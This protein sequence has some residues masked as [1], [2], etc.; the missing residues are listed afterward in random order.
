MGITTLVLPM[1]FGALFTAQSP[2]AAPAP[3][4]AVGQSLIPV[5]VEAGR[6]LRL[7]L[8][9]RTTVNHVGQ[10]VS[11]TLLDPVY[12]HDR[13][14]LP[15]GTTAMGH[16]EILDSPSKA[17]RARAMLAGDFSGHRLVSVRF[18]TLV[19]EN[20][21]RLE[22]S[23]S[24]TQGVEHV[25]RKVAGERKRS[26]R[27]D[28]VKDM[29]IRA[30]PYHRQFLA[31]GTTY[32]ASL[33]AP[34]DLGTAE[35]VPHALPGTPPAPDSHLAA[36]L[37]TPVGSA[38]SPLGTPVE[39]VLTQPLFSS[40]GAVILPE[41]SKL[42]G[43]VTVS[44]PARR[45]RR[46]GQLR[47]LLTRVVDPDTPADGLRASLQGVE[48]SD[49]NRLS[50][51]EEGGVRTTSSPA[52]FA[53]PALAALAFAG[54]MHGRVDLDTDGMGP[55]TEYGGVVS[56]TT[57]GFIGMSVF[58]VAVNQLGR[59]VVIVTTSIGLARSLYAT[60]FARGAEVAFPVNTPLTLQLSPASFRSG[61][62]GNKR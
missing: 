19:L 41:G 58:G 18:D 29:A 22:I 1:I 46:T 52:R 53:A 51:D 40:A 13:I 16:I 39:A 27:S 8:N 48:T 20:G 23:T 61:V 7:A 15:A 42:A 24:T 38:T 59:P 3:A 26:S 14:A 45:F 4:S 17:N 31:K 6:P 10:P 62:A 49:A 2:E 43:E 60:V 56:S 47:F 57:G 34:L 35:H 32:A 33:L 44:R 30:L 25:T 36:R 54:T 9:R 12:V 28:R 55:E 5:V 21:R 37:L 11:A 50:I